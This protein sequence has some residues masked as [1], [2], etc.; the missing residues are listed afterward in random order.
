MAFTP[1]GVEFVGKGFSKYLNQ[2]TKADK[3]QQGL[4]KSA[5]GIG[6]GFSSLGSSVLG[7]GA[8]LAK[9]AVGGVAALTAGLVAFG[10]SSIREGAAYTKAMSNVKAITGAT[11]KQFD[12]LTESAKILGR[13][14]KFTATEAAEGMSFLAMA[15]FEVNEVISAMP[16]VLN[17]AAAG[18]LKLGQSADI[19]SNVLTGFGAEA[20]Q[21]GRFV[22][23]LTKTFTSSNTNLIQLGQAMKFVA[24]VAADLG[25]SVEQT[26]AA[27]GALG[28]G[29]IQAS[30]AGT[31]LRTALLN[32]A[33]PVGKGKALLEKLGI[34]VFDAQGEMLPFPEIIGNFNEAM[35]G[36]SD[37][38]RESTLRT[39]IGKR[40]ISGFS[41]LLKKGEKGLEDFGQELLD[42]G[43]TAAKIAATQLDNLSGDITLFK[44]VLSGIKID[45]FEALEPILRGLAQQGKGLLETFGPQLSGAFGMLS[46]VIN[47]I[48]S[49]VSELFAV[50]QRG[51]IAGLAESLGITPEITELLD[52]IA[53]S[54][55]MLGQ[56][57]L[58]F[59]LPGLE[60]LSEGGLID[61]INSAISFLNQ[62]FEA[63]QGAILGIGAVV[64]GGVLAAL[65]AGLFALLTPIN[66]II[67]AA[68]LL[69]A[70]WVGN[71]GNIQGI[72]MSAIATLTNL[73]NTAFPIIQAIVMTT[74]AV[75]SSIFAGIMSV[76][77]GQVVPNLQ[78]AFDNITMAI[79]SLGLNW[80]DIWNAILTAVGIVA[81]AIG[82]ILLALVATITGV[83][84]GLSSVIL[85]FSQAIQSMAVFVEQIITGIIQF[86]LGFQQFWTSIFAGD[87]PGALEGFKLAMSGVANFI[88]GV[89]GALFTAVTTPLVAIIT[90]LGT[91]VTSVIEFFTTLSDTLVGNSIIPD[92]VMAIIDIFTSMIEPILSVFSTLSEGIASVLGAIF[93]GGEEEAPS[94]A[95]DPAEAVAGLE[96]ISTLT[97][98]LNSAIVNIFST[99]LPTLTATVLATVAQIIPQ[100]M[101]VIQA[102]TQLNM[103]LAEMYTVHLPTL[104]QVSDTTTQAM[105]TGFTQVNAVVTQTISLIVQLTAE[106]KR[107]GAETKKVTDAM[108]KAFKEVGEAVKKLADNVKSAAQS[109]KTD[110]VQALNSAT[111]AAEK[112]RSALQGA[113]MAAGGLGG[114]L[115]AQAGIGIGAA[116]GIGF[117]AGTLGFTVPQGFPNDSFPIRVQSGEEV[118]VAPAN[119]SIDEIVMDT[120][121][122]GGQSVIVEVNVGTINTPMDLAIVTEQVKR[123]IAGEVN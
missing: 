84:S 77:M 78:A 97:E 20:D 13:T 100:W 10:V 30:M 72:T 14:T 27:M 93:G 53:T 118:L 95:F 86:V 21:T 71:W 114:A 81:A 40:A 61:T 25:L 104:Q 36:M 68:A 89:F 2:L 74:G 23:V 50:F 8:N 107:L 103:L 73:F 106:I 79:N 122:V 109:I 35:E 70:A 29:G 111:E 91:F 6:S 101:S 105:V 121:G 44:S 99:T 117:Q 52:K 65:V 82:A 67:A 19:V 43:G 57:I 22:D 69:G 48:I 24:P 54:A 47:D 26:A 38:Q 32:L 45:V 51:G 59:L 31:T 60:G 15:G 37:A 108:I 83:I 63:L 16:G 76:I 7:F 88:S 11:E 112:L 102:I 1:T 18:N 113:T 120:F 42:S 116:A 96:E 58:S 12:S 5:S 55:A 4:G 62:N 123:V 28:D 94:F 92:M 39:I 41:L 9:V 80:S 98:Q 110:L 17:L 115:E 33:A 90:F 64:A 46:V 85:V 66:L 49:L 34:A 75:I 87:L 3:A 119:S 56:A